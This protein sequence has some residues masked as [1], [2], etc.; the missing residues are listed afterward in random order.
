MTTDSVINYNEGKNISNEKLL[1]LPVYVLA[2]AAMEDVI[3]EKNAGRIKAKIIL[4]LANGPTTMAAEEKLLKK[5]VMIVPDVLANAG[6]VIV[7]YFEWVQNIRHFYWEEEKVQDRLEKQIMRAFSKVWQ[8][9]PQARGNMRLAAYIVA[10]DRLVKAL[11][12]RGI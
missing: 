4:E 12:V 11:K 6:G 1:E 3:S 8:T 10:V 9:M 2:P 5:G 7:S